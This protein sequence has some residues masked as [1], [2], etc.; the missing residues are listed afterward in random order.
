MSGS[1]N[2]RFDQST[3]QTVEELEFYPHKI[4]HDGIIID[5]HTEKSRL[6]Q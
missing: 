4:S 1:K 3:M 5:G 6:R 2:T